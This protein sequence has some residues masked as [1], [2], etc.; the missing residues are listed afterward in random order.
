MGIKDEVAKEYSNTTCCPRCE[1]KEVSCSF[2]K[3]F[4]DEVDKLY[5]SAIKEIINGNKV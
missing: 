3:E 5:E 2:C 1:G 4:A